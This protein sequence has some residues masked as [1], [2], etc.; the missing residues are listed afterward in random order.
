MKGGTVGVSRVNT[1][2]V[3]R[4]SPKFGADFSVFFPYVQRLST[5]RTS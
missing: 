5:V 4:H 2:D 1:T 3:R